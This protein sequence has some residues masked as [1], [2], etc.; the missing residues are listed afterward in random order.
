[1]N[2]RSQEANMMDKLLGKHPEVIVL[3]FPLKYWNILLE[4]I[5]LESYLKGRKRINVVYLVI[6]H[7]SFPISHQRP[8]GYQICIFL[9]ILI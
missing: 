5:L 4:K 6:V 8:N 3:N 2:P 7:Q 1:M 9:I